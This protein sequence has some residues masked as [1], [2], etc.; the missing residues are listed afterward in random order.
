MMEKQVIFNFRRFYGDLSKL[1]YCD[2]YEK[3]VLK[4]KLVLMYT[5]N[6]TNDL[7][8]M[9]MDEYNEMCDAMEQ[10]TIEGRARNYGLSELKRWRS[11]VLHLIQLDGVDTSDWARVD[12]FCMNPRIAG[13][14]FCR[15]DASE[16]E[17]LSIKL[18]MILKKNNQ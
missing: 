8:Y 14:K 4:K 1:R 7:K 13:K 17:E 18:R 3:E 10:Q 11:T 16:L 9:H 6:R 15:L 5:H 2:G 12:A